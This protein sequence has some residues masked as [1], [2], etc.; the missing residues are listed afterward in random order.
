[1]VNGFGGI[2]SLFEVVCDVRVGWGVDAYICSL[3][4]RSPKAFIRVSEE[5]VPKGDDKLPG[6]NTRAQA[7]AGHRRKN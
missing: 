7:R 4:W 6:E 5:C 2:C 1:M 3:F